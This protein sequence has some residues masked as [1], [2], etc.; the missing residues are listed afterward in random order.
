MLCTDSTRIIANKTT[1][2][3]IEGATMMLN[4]NST[5]MLN[6]GITAV[7]AYNTT[8]E[9]KQF[10]KKGNGNG[11]VLNIDGLNIYIAGDTE[12]IAEMKKLK[13][14]D[15]AFL[16]VNQPYTMTVDQCI[17]AAKI[18]KPRTLIPYHFGNT[19]VN[20]IKAKLECD[21]I[22]VLLRNFKH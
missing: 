5:E 15:I 9:H 3:L 16:P 10:H 4:G 11:Y 14:I 1:A 19:P 13:D 18:I 7:A 22:N 2:P 6:I 20:E 21:E 12:P 8:P 17:E